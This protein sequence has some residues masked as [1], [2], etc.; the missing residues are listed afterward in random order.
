MSLHL[1]AL[2]LLSSVAAGDARPALPPQLAAARTIAV[3]AHAGRVAAASDVKLEYK[4]KTDAEAELRRDSY[5]ALVDDP[6][7]ADVVLL[8]LGGGKLSWGG[9]LPAPIRMQLWGTSDVMGVVFSQNPWSSVPLWIHQRSE[10][11]DVVRDLHKFLQHG[12]K[13][14]LGAQSQPAAAAKGS[15][16]PSGKTSKEVVPPEEVLKAKTVWVFYFFYDLPTG[17]SSSDAPSIH[18]RPYALSVTESLRKWGKFQI[19]EEPA[20]ADLILAVYRDWWDYDWVGEV[21]G[22]RDDERGRQALLVFN[23]R[24]KPNWAAVPLWME[25]A[26]DWLVQKDDY[27]QPDLV[28]IL[29]KDIHRGERDS[30][31]ATRIPSNG[32]DSE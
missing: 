12:G 20:K 9:L 28:S 31:Q 8:V 6:N 17:W 5:L 26:H 19:V 16:P 2:L 29:R 4:L 7:K 21:S 22:T 14:R 25:Q 23:G 18:S 11:R 30:A 15:P 32:K 3:V 24:D 27:A 10:A 13:A 1:V